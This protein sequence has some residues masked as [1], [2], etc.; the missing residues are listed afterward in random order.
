MNDAYN[1]RIEQYKAYRALEV[2]NA[3]YYDSQIQALEKKKYA[4]SNMTNIISELY[5][6]VK[7][8]K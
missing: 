5:N 8:Q 7:K 6:D 3:A 1:Q 4:W 2:E